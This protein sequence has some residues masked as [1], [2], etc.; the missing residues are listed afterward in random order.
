MWALPMITSDDLSAVSK[1]LF[2]NK[3]LI[4]YDANAGILTCPDSVNRYTHSNKV[5]PKSIHFNEADP[6]FSFIYQIVP[7]YNLKQNTLNVIELQSFSDLVRTRR[8][9]VIAE[10]DDNFSTIQE[11][12]DFALATS[13][14]YK[15]FL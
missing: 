6:A 11:M 3:S 10:F 12:F 7:L 4:K 2:C 8:F 5:G 14:Q 9:N 15:L 1:C 13:K